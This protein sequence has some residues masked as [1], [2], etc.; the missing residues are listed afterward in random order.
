MTL[1][2]INK[3]FVGYDEATK[4]LQHLHEQMVAKANTSYPPYNLRKTEDHKYLLE[5]AV[6]GFSE[7]EIAVQ[8]VGD[9]LV[10]EAEKRKDDT[11]NLFKGWLHQGIAY[12]GFT[13]TFYLDNQYEV[14]QAEL[15]DGLLKVY[16]GVQESKK[17]KK[18][19]IG[20]QK[21]LTI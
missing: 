4:R 9:Q 12:R 15:K 11:D 17:P 8:V 3:F 6:A 2:D 13:R 16:L 5:L 7:D 1:K 10:I 21:Q 14:T 20:A 19:P 18:I